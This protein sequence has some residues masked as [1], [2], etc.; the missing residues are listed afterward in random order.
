MENKT[1]RIIVKILAF[2][3]LC[4]A[5]TAL[6]INTQQPTV[7]NGS[8]TENKADTNAE[9]EKQNNVGI[10]VSLPDIP[11]YSGLPFTEINNN[12][13][14]FTADELVTVAFEKYGSLDSKGRCTVAY[15]NICKE[16]MPTEK[17]GSVG[18]IKPS[19]WH[20]VK[21]DF[22]NG[23]YL[24]N[25]CHLIGYQLAGENANSQ[26]LITGTRYLNITA[27][28][29]F[30]DKVADYVYST[31]NHVLY[32]VTPL[33]EGDN[34]LASG[35]LMEGYS[36]EDNGKGIC[37]NVFCYNVQPGVVINYANGESYAKEETTESAYAI[38]PTLSLYILPSCVIGSGFAPA[39]ASIV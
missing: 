17:R 38:I 16:L 30:E 3:I 37:Y 5:S 34:L 13:P 20:T 29:P 6:N 25:R 19:G 9:T 11:E 10:N 12:I 14:F 22:I 27:M 35:V 39:P 1:K 18:M 36:V 7:I 28:L 32:R 26:N 31:H 24:Y 33:F 8:A 2:A 23:K 21:Y 4:A 15:A